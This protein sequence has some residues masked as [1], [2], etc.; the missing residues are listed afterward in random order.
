[1]MVRY[2][3]FLSFLF[4]F[5]AVA[6][7]GV[8]SDPEAYLLLEKMWQ[9]SRELNY[10]GTFV[11]LNDG[12]METMR[13]VHT[14]DGGQERERLTSLNGVQRE[15]VRDNHSVVYILPDSQL[16][17][18]KLRS[19]DDGLPLHAEE[20]S[21]FYQLKTLSDERVAGRQANVVLIMPLD[22]YRYG[23][24]LFLDAEHG[25]PLKSEVLDDA[26]DTVSQV[27]FTQLN[28]DPEIRISKE[29]D[30]EGDVMNRGEFSW[31]N[32]A[33]ARRLNPNNSVKQQLSP[34]GFPTLPDGFRLTVHTQRPAAEGRDNVDHFLFSDG[35][36]SF[37][38]Y[39][40]R[41]A[42]KKGLSGASRMGAINVYGRRLDEYQV[43][44]VGEV[45]ER[46]VREL[47]KGVTATKLAQ[48]GD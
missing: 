42:N 33:P 39:I 40:E 7:G 38:V 30:G 43:T 36:A 19:G 17:A 46:T 23:H 32:Q 34:W 3:R 45:P 31:V 22:N 14:A 8:E 41:M 13:L 21:Q 29:E 26:G 37:S 27:M 20:L 18:A 16:V 24:R 4:V 1:M 6:D 12:H 2:L 48:T 47:A 35:L 5:S 11:H 15:V 10:E 28:V 44:A 25:L 9:S